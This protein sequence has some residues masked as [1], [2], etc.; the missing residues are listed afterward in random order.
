MT[1]VFTSVLLTAL[2]GVMVF[3]VGSGGWE[4]GKNK[5][6]DGFASSIL[7]LGE[8]DRPL[9]GEDIY[10]R[11]VRSV[12]MVEDNTGHGSG[13]VIS[14][15]Q[16]LIVTNYHVVRGSRRVGLLFPLYDDQ[17]EVIT[18]LRKYMSRI[19]E[20]GVVGDVLFQDPRRDLAL[21]RVD[22]MPDKVEEVRLAN[23][24]AV[25]GSNVYSVGNSGL[26]QRQVE[27]G[28][29]VEKPLLWRLTK[30]IVRGRTEYLAKLGS[31]RGNKKSPFM[32]NCMVL[33]TDAPINPGDSGGP[34]VNNRAE[35][36][37][38]VSFY[39]VLQRQVS[40]NIDLTELRNFLAEKVPEV[41]P[42]R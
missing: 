27:E 15:Q 12:V 14:R 18:D 35:L 40:G 22:R 37:G 16:R 30:G 5:G 39:N 9:A 3:A 38:V 36:V 20:A 7:R 42:Y 41:L 32:I 8:A 21:V 19:R 11:L 31:G 10:R 2:I 23:N 24:P 4:T 26:Q 13:F 33:E 17:G 25:T 1:G 6:G 28:L 29:I 34:I